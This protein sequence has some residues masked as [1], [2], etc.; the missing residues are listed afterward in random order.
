MSENLYLIKE[1]VSSEIKIKSSTFICT[2]GYAE[3]IEEAKDFISNI[4]TKYKDATHNCWAYII[5]KK[6]EIFH[7]SDDGEPSGTAGKPMLNT[8]NKHNLTNIASVV[9]RYYGGTKLGVRGLIEAY[10]ES[11]EDSISKA[12]IEEW[13]EKSYYTVSV[14]YDFSEILK[15]KIKS[16][17]GEITN[18]SYTDQVSID[19]C[20]ETHKS[21]DLYLYLDELKKRGLLK[22]LNE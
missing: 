22:F 4:S 8:L 16:M 7:S 20:I 14:S 3:T 2:I 10:S 11:V 13:I 19:I 6:G 17:S 1:T 5:G 9:T 12:S 15:H 21:E 18:I